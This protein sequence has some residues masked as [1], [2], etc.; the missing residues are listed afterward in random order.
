M[1]LAAHFDGLGARD[2]DVPV[3]D[4]VRFAVVGLGGFATRFAL[5]ALDA[6]AHCRTTVLVSRS[7]AKAGRLAA[8]FGVEHTLTYDDLHDGV[9]REEYDAVYVCTPNA[10]HFGPAETASAFGKHV[11]CEKPLAT[12]TKR[13]TRL[14]EICDG[15]DGTLMVAYRMQIDPVM[16]RVRDLVR[17]GFVGDPLRIHA[18][19]SYPVL[20][21]GGPDQWRLD[22]DLAGGGALMDV[23]IHALNTVRFLLDA[24]PIAVRGETASPDEPFA[25]VDQHVGFELAFPGGVGAACTASFTGYASSHLELLGTEGRI[26]VDPA[27]SPATRR[28]IALER[29]DVRATVEGPEVDEIR[30]QFDYF[31]AH[32][33]TDRRPEPDGQDGLVDMRTIDAIYESAETGRRVDLER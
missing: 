16:R 19:F 26:R 14:V 6:A 23:G 9:D 1:K 8:R 31:A 25:E 2:W 17:E 32:V 4:P 30:E 5:P 18:G 20:D 15:T 3:E 27:F 28:R 21:A 24:D 22:R 10:R 33:R 29:G 12:T 11:L 7:P 13:A